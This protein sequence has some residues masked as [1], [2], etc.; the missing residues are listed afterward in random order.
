[1]PLPPRLPTVHVSRRQ[2]QLAPEERKKKV[3]Q[4]TNTKQ[5]VLQELPASSPVTPA[6]S[7]LP[8]EEVEPRRWARSR[9]RHPSGKKKSKDGRVGDCSLWT[10]VVSPRRCWVQAPGADSSVSVPPRFLKCRI[11]EPRQLWLCRCPSVP[12]P[13][14]RAPS[15]N[16]S[17]RDPENSCRRTRRFCASVPP[18]LPTQCSNFKGGPF[19]FKTIQS[20]RKTPGEG[21]K[22]KPERHGNRGGKKRRQNIINKTEFGPQIL[23]GTECYVPIHMTSRFR[24]SPG[25]M[26]SSADNSY[27]EGC[28]WAEDT[29][30]KPSQK[31]VGKGAQKAERKGG[32]SKKFQQHKSTPRNGMFILPK[33]SGAGKLK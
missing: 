18:Y 2:L 27:F 31:D 1:M 4:G 29:F 19:C 25:K 7:P 22:E 9:T 15:R 3:S 17:F 33:R 13:S 11:K 6:P 24:E 8:L 30:F 14:T 32:G 12:P 23:G 20:T 16:L 10:R 26:R 21:K 5:P 28:R